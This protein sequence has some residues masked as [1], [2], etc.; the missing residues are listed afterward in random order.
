MIEDLKDLKDIYEVARK[1]LVRFKEPIEELVKLCGCLK[2]VVENPD[3]LFK[4][5][6]PAYR[7]FFL[8]EMAVGALKGLSDTRSRD[9]RVSNSSIILR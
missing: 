3:L 5:Q 4:H 8:E 9:D 7:K 1:E 6:D 2:A